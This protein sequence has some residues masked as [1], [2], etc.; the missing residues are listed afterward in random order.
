MS[1]E[2]LY[3]KLSKCEFWLKEVQFLGHVINQEGIKVDPTKI[4]AISNWEPSKTPTDVR[5]FLSLTGYYRR[6]IEDFFRIATPLTSLTTKNVKF[7]WTESRKKAFETLK[8]RLINAPVLSLPEG[9]EDFVVYSDASNRGLGC[10]LMQR[11]KV[12]AYASRQLKEHEKR[13]L[14][15]DLELEAV[16]FALKIWRHYLLS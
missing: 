4:E 10:V 8:E 16:V 14:T 1:K 6:L 9:N 13:Y 15:H 11:R 7:V 12:I 2:K 5:S 3:V